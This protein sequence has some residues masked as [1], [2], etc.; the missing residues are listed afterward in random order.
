MR[1]LRGEK[2]FEHHCSSNMGASAERGCSRSMVIHVLTVLMN[3]LSRCQTRRS[4]GLCGT[5]VVENSVPSWHLSEVDK[6]TPSEE[7][8]FFFLSS[9]H[10]VGQSLPG[11]IL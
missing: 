8:N 4:G 3:D 2:F 7:V 10:T 5:H 9:R 11:C 6:M 1:N